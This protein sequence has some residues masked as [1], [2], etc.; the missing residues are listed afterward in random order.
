M[1]SIGSDIYVTTPPTQNR[2]EVHTSVR[3][4]EPK[5]G[6]RTA[7]THWV[8]LERSG[9]ICPEYG[10]GSH[11][12]DVEDRPGRE[13]AVTDGEAAGTSHVRRPC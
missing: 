6:S 9:E 13:V 4:V 11:S 5:C 2:Y 10:V 1:N 3:V 7:T 8:V 12:K